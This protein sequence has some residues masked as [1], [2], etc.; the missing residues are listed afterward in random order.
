MKCPRCKK[1]PKQKHWNAKWCI[2]CAAEL[3]KRPAGKLTRAQQQTVRRLAGRMFIKELA[4]VVGTS[5]SSLDRWAKQNGVNINALKTPDALVKEVCE[6]YA[7]HG[8]LKTQK[9][10]PHVRI[11]SI[12][13]RFATKPRQVRWTA[14]QLH[15]LVKMAGLVSFSRQADHFAR[16]GAHVGSIKSVWMKRFGTSGGHIN[17]LSHNVARQYVKRSCPY[18]ETDFWETR[19]YGGR[20]YAA[21]RRR[22][23]LWVDVADHLEDHV[24]AH[25]AAAIQAMAKFQR[26]LHGRK[27]RSSIQ[28]ILE[29]A[30]A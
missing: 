24:P 8:K 21:S 11:R 5:D 20:D 27:Y 30:E 15:E 2:K 18:Y 26:W 12:V 14:D 6:Y 1:R 3:R 25:L 22:I 28:T 23:A 13:E 16:P 4:K 29:G 7:D 9:R 10:F 17:G 19:I